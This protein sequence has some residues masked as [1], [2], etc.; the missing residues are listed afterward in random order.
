[1]LTTVRSPLRISFFG[2]GT[3][4]PE[5]FERR[6]STVVGMAI[7]KYIYISA[8][9]LSS[10]LEYRYRVAYSK[11]EKVDALEEI[12][13]PVIRTVLDMY[14]YR[15]PLDISISSDV[16]AN[17][18]LGSSSA[19][20]VGFLKLMAE[21]LSQTVTKSDLARTAVH[22]ERERLGEVV[23]VQDQHHAAFGG[24]NRF[25]F[26]KN[27]VSI[28]PVQIS[29]PSLQALCDSMMLVYTGIRRHA[30]ATLDEQ[31]QKTRSQIV[32]SE[33]E[34]MLTLA[35][36]SVNV[37]EGCRS[38]KIVSTFGALLHE[39]WQVKKRLSNKVSS[40][41]IDE[42]YAKALAQGAT[43]GKLNGAGAGGF[44]LVLVPPERQASFIAAMQPHV[45]MPIRIDTLGAKIM[46]N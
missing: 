40:G 1:M 16:P 39:G 23:G 15:E 45:C 34:T 3:D 7:N 29:G 21:M 2:G 11:L 30:S 38:D 17:T 32:D 4:Y 24:I 14:N 20:T 43:G 18:G 46:H 35:E 44:L 13:H 41:P 37:L 27:R 22:V 10:I 28:S 5:F 12:E 25:D 36:E 31:I 33:L 9:R 42:L 6:H 26:S 19:F 8:L